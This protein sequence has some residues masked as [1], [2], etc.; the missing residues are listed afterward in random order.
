MYVTLFT[1]DGSA[2]S[3]LEGQSF[4][5]GT[6]TVCSIVGAID[7]EQQIV[8][9]RFMPGQDKQCVNIVILDDELPEGQQDF[10]ATL[11]TTA[12]RMILHPDRAIVNISDNDRK[13]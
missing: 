6:I 11:T 8:L 12:S 1:Q 10:S 7:Y 2:H 4:M 5:E 9:L 3:K 13:D